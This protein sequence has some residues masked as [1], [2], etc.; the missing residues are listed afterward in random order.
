[1]INVKSG[2]LTLE[3]LLVLVEPAWDE[4]DIVVTTLVLCMCMCCV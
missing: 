3:F 4:R 2:L 1:M